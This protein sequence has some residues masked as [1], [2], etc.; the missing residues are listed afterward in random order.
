METII[1]KLFE[2]QNNQ[3]YLKREDLIPFCFGGNKA[4]KA[5]LFFEEIDSGNYD[6]IVTY[7]SSSSNH[8]RVIANMAAA[9]KMPCYII[10]PLESSE[11]TFNS[12]LMEMFHVKMKTVPVKDVHDAIQNTLKKLREQGAR[13]Y[14]IA[15]GGHGNLGT[16][17]YVECY[18]EIKDYE[19]REKLHFEY[20]F[21]ASGTGTT[22]AGLVS[23]KL[24]NQD[25]RT[26]IGISIARRNP[27]GGSVV[28]ESILQYLQYCNCKI[29]RKTIHENTIFVD[30]YISDGY[31]KSNAAVDKLIQKMMY[32]YGIP[33]DQTYVGK[34][35]Y[36]MLQ[37]IEKEKISNKNILF[38]HTGGTPL[39]FDSI[40]TAEMERTK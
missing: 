26:I 4:R 6:C 38:L 39:F 7:G 25:D 23:G 16:K 27:Y 14:F 29:S 24:L 31:G 19:I 21:H 5:K 13:P 32:K 1:Q 11:P 36:G 34:A 20:V 22:Q 15:G 9:R 3:I 37:Y 18:S 28:E 8:C 12:I 17:A 10:S 35:F 2:Y 40:M 30:D 33:M